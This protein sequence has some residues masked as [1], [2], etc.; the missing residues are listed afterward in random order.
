M[1]GGHRPREEA[2]YDCGDLGVV[3]LK[4]EMAGI[5]ESNL[6]VR[7]IAFEGFGPRRQ[8]EGIVLA[9]DRQQ[10][11][12]VATPRMRVCLRPR[13]SGSFKSVSFL[14]PVSRVIGIH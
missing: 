8:K 9:P 3:R 1:R 11:R 2:T 4:R 5:E 12:T 14:V 7:H 10:R 13:Y 6:G